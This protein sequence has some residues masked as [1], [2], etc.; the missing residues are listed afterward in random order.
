[1]TNV[2][3]YYYHYLSHAWDHSIYIINFFAPQFVNF[4]GKHEKCGQGNA[5]VN[6]VEKASKVFQIELPKMPD[7]HN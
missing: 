3:H 1:M 5:Q 7:K 4:I 6:Q 2:T